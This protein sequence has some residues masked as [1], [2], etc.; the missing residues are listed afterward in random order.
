MSSGTHSRNSSSSIVREIQFF[1][2][3]PLPEQQV[4]PV[5]NLYIYP[6]WVSFLITFVNFAA[7]TWKREEKS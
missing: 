7:K 6:E 2:P 4:S 5:N 1:S 3:V